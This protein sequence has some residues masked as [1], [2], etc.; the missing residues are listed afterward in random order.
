MFSTLTL[1]PKALIHIFNTCQLR[2]T[3]LRDP[4][5][6]QGQR[7]KVYM[8]VTDT[9][10][11]LELGTEIIQFDDQGRV[12]GAQRRK[13]VKNQIKPKLRTSFEVSKWLLLKDSF[14]VILTEI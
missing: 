9:Y 14:R 5:L 4:F 10:Y 1:K 2:I 7:I 8:F 6:P 3:A 12:C 13:F 11:S